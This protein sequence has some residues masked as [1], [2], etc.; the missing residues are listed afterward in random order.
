LQKTPVAALSRAVAGTL[1]RSILICL[2]GSRKAVAEN[3]AVILPALEHALDKLQGDT[4][5]CA[6]YFEA[7]RNGK[8]A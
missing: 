4:R 3:L 5:D 8:T 2:P 7:V 1:G 6:D